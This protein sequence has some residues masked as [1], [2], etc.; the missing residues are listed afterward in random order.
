MTEGMIT[1]ILMDLATDYWKLDGDIIV[2]ETEGIGFPNVTAVAAHNRLLE[3]ASRLNRE[4]NEL[5][6]RMD[7][8]EK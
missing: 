4:Y 1:D 5:K 3:W 8:L 2:T 6:F 7:G